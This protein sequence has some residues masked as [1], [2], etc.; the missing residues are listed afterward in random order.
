MCV[1]SCNVYKRVSPARHRGLQYTYL[2]TFDTAEEAAA[3]YDR[4]AIAYKGKNALTNFDISTYEAELG[5]ITQMRKEDLKG[6]IQTFS[7]QPGGE[8]VLE[9]DA[10]QGN[11]GNKKTLLQLN[12]SQVMV[13][14]GKEEYIK[15]SE[16][17][18][19]SRSK[20]IAPWKKANDLS[21]KELHQREKEKRERKVLAP[22]DVNVVANA[23]HNEADCCDG[24]APF[25]SSQSPKSEPVAQKLTTN[26]CVQRHRR[27]PKRRS[28]AAAL[29]VLCDA[30]ADS[31]TPAHPS[32]GGRPEGKRRRATTV[33]G[34]KAGRPRKKG[35]LSEQGGSGVAPKG[36]GAS[37]FV[38]GNAGAMTTPDRATDSI[39]R[40]WIEST[41]CVPNVNLH[42]KPKEEAAIATDVPERCQM[43]GATRVSLDGA[44]IQFFREFDVA[45]QPVPAMTTTTTMRGPEQRPHYAMVGHTLVSVDAPSQS[46]DEMRLSQISGVRM[47]MDI[48]SLMAHGDGRLPSSQATAAVSEPPRT[49]KVLLTPTPATSGGPSSLKIE[50]DDKNGT[51][52]SEQMRSEGN[53]ADEDATA[54]FKMSMPSRVFEVPGFI[55]PLIGGDSICLD[56]HETAF[57]RFLPLL[58]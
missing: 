9:L 24:I 45:A 15:T 44:E 52:V 20:T 22:R 11:P 56:P 51:T 31:E 35:P 42:T 58:P 14:A 37:E 41:P 8:P 10:D 2:G 36:H 48:D 3:A 34:A 12:A 32:G 55:S 28:K 13:L 38:I 21:K 4:A 25:S 46:V 50:D 26:G 29:D 30:V 43:P 16:E 57:Q 53:G 33:S 23:D 18:K 1:P 49:M 39:M 47:E 27:A 40:R 7:V 19:R 17:R 5:I 54:R 6:A